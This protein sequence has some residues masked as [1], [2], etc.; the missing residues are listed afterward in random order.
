MASDRHSRVRSSATL[1]QRFA[2]LIGIFALGF[3]IFGVLSFRTVNTV[4]VNGELYNNIVRD[5]DLVADILP[6]PEYIIEPYLVAQQAYRAAAAKKGSDTINALIAR[7]ETLHKEYE[8]RHAYWIKEPLPKRMAQVFLADSYA[9][10]QRFF[11][12][13][14]DAFIPA[15]RSGDTAAASAALDTMSAAYEAHRR[16]IDEVVKLA[17]AGE[18]AAE[19]DGRNMIRR[20]YVMLAVVLA[21]SVLFAIIFAVV[22]ARRLVAALGGE[23]DYAADIARN[24]A[25]GDLTEQIK[26]RKGDES[27]VLAAMKSMQDSLQETVSGVRSVSVDLTATSGEVAQY[28]SET[29][30]L[31]QD[32]LVRTEQIASAINEMAAT[33]QDV[34]RNA[35]EAADGASQ[36]DNASKRGAEVVAHTI[37]SIE[38]LAQEVNR[39]A[40]TVG[41]LAQGS[42]NI[43]TVLEVIQGVAEQTNLL[44]LNAA[45]EAARAGDQGRG[46]AVVASEVRSLASRTQESTR[47][48]EG[49]IASLNSGAAAATAAIEGGQQRSQEMLQ[50]AALARDALHEIQGAVTHISDMNASIASATEEQAA[51]AEEIS[52]N[53]TDIATGVGQITDTAMATAKSADKLSEFSRQLESRIEQFRLTR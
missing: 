39:V 30:Q 47:E 17:N 24:V 53:I 43:S 4:K 16:A 51:V 6:P 41:T 35:A 26:V 48:I 14:D 52:H 1:G 28:G 46:F 42:A 21:A 23:P 15:L 25:K 11:R 20:S 12:V 22:F 50:K 9:P 33:V 18:T 5:K 34:A 31:V 49:L 3:V 7:L 40:E 32:N 38:A 44:A 2:V 29:Q 8:A 36:A 13:A 45:I 27:S 37:T 19:Q 10:A